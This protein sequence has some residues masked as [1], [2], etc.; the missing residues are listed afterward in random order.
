[1]IIDFRELDQREHVSKKPTH[2]IDFDV[3]HEPLAES[4]RLSMIAQGLLRDPD[5][6]AFAEAN[7]RMGA[8]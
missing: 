1:M 7:R 4:I 3:S 2:T 5:D 6:A 8:K